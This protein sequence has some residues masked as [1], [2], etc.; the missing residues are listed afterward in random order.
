MK[1]ITQ[2]VAIKPFQPVT[3]SLTFESKAELDLYHKELGKC[4]GGTYQFFNAL[5]EA[6]KAAK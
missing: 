5:A 2:A 1:V 4:S 3:I 6:L